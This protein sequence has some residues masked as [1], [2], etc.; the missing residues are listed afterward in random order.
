MSRVEEI[1]EMLVTNPSSHY[2]VTAETLEFLTDEL[3][4]LEDEADSLTRI[5]DKANTKIRTLEDKLHLEYLA[6]HKLA[7]ELS[8]AIKCANC[9][10]TDECEKE[11]SD[12]SCDDL[13]YL[14][15]GGGTEW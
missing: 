2:L 14:W 15:A 11:D 7:Y 8:F 4:D 1:V 3:I 5:V 13:L 10:L 9:P 6:S 12:K